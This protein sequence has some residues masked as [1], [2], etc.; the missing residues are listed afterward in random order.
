MINRVNS[1]SVMIV[2]SPFSL[3]E[4]WPFNPVNPEKS[5]KSCQK[6]FPLAAFSS[7]PQHLDILGR[8]IHPRV[9]TGA[10]ARH[11]FGAHLEGLQGDIMAQVN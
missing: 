9:G 10:I 6:N 1:S 7:F 2:P 11:E 8:D 3:I 4:F 5:C